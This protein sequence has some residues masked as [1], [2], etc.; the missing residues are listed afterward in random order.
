MSYALLLAATPTVQE[1]SIF[2]FIVSQEAAASHSSIADTV[3]QNAGSEQG[4]APVGYFLRSMSAANFSLPID[5]ARVAA[6]LEG[7]EHFRLLPAVF[8]KGMGYHFDGLATVMKMSV[9]GGR[10]SV[11]TRA[12]ESQAEQRWRS[13]LFYGTGTGPTLGT[14]VCFQNPGV[15][16]LPIAGQLWLTIDT[17]SWG[18]VDPAT[19]A[20]VAGAKVEVGGALTLNAHP[21]CDPT[22]GE[23]FVQHPCPAKASPLSAA[24][25]ISQ[26]VPSADGGAGMNTTRVSSATL[27]R[28]KLIQHSHSPC[29]TPSYVVS[30]IDAFEPRKP[31]GSNSGLLKFARQ[32][33]D[34]LWLVMDRR[35]NTSRVLRSPGHSFVNNHF[36]NCYEEPA[37]GAV[38]VEA[39]AATSDYLDNYFERNLKLPTVD[40]SRLFSPPISCRVPT[41]ALLQEADGGG[42]AA[43]AADIECVPMLGHGGPT[44]PA[45]IAFDYP[46]YNP[47]FKMRPYRFFYAIAPSSAASRWFDTLVKVDRANATGG[48]VAASWSSPGVYLTEADFVPRPRSSDGTAN[49]EDDG[50]LLTVLYN[51]T[52][53]NSFFGVFDARTVA[54]L[55]LYPLGQLVVPFHAHG[56]VCLP[57]EACFTN[58]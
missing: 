27:P 56:I 38:V 36:W 10:L 11:K 17:S 47:R 37:G 7:V 30:K 21:A 22:T 52:A 2:D 23:C 48:V 43:V 42:D 57:G 18:R 44:P 29:I 41:T 5:D 28:A 46:T 8:P 16:L 49:A 58:P 34:D 33:E 32:A 45:L 4:D 13:C 39:V 51:A 20:T 15:N 54:P 31:V 53:D 12:F 26:L 55:G 19:L 1:P 6:A 24:V 9:S 40:W 50:L 25:C 14:H 35:T 3:E